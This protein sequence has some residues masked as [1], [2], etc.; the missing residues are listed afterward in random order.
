MTELLLSIHTH[1]VDETAQFAA[2]IAFGCRQGDC[3]LLRGDLGTG[4]TA[5]A[6]GFI[7]SLCP[8]VQVTSP[9]FTLV[10]TY[11]AKDSTVWHFDLYRLEKADEV[12]ET[13]IEDALRD[14]IMLIEWPDI[15]SQILPVDALEVQIAYRKNENDRLIS[16]RSA[17]M[18]WKPLFEV[19][20][21]HVGLT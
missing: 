2:M 9:T 8:G 6:R 5:F 11:D 14:G 18:R 1:S 3:I 13:G 17:D 19:L 16:V 21:N 12:Y 4:K 15:I 7:S 20:E 10:Q